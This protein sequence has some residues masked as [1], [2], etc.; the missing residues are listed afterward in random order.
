MPLCRE[1]PAQRSAAPSLQVPRVLTTIHW[2]PSA[3][4]L[5]WSQTHLNRK[6]TA[7]MPREVWLP[8]SHTPEPVAKSCCAPGRIATSPGGEH[9]KEARFFLATALGDPAGTPRALQ[10]ST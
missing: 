8:P 4:D 5:C 9:L 2:I 7:S 6:S 1:H 10:S 3:K